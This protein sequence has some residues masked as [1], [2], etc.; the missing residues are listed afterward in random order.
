MRGN[1]TNLCGIFGQIGAIKNVVNQSNK[2]NGS[3]N[4]NPDILCR[5]GVSRNSRKY[6]IRHEQKIRLVNSAIFE[7][8][9]A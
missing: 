9:N 3:D 7:I 6:I 2:T 4:R 1:V 5:N 8:D